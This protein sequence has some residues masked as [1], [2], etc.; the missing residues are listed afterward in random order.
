MKVSVSENMEWVVCGVW[1]S[2]NIEHKINSILG[3]NG[4]TVG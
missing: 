4:G 3:L 2:L 1:G